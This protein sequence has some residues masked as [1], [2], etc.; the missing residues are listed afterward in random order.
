M[1]GAQP[2]HIDRYSY[3]LPELL[4]PLLDRGRMAAEAL[5]DQGLRDGDFAELGDFVVV[6][7]R[8]DAA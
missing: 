8:F 5:P 1:Q 7:L 4:Q 6:T 3:F 2:R